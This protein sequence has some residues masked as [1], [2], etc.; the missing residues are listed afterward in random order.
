MCFSRS[1]HLAVVRRS[2]PS[3]CDTAALVP[4][5]GSGR[6][7]LLLDEVVGE[8]ERRAEILAAVGRS[9]L[10]KVGDGFEGEVSISDQF[11][12]GKQ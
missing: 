7:A 10:W 11:S 6:H 3:G 4:Q 8:G 9:V 1:R 2:K 5:N 12:E